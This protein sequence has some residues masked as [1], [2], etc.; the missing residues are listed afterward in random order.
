MVVNVYTIL[1]KA[2]TKQL[3]LIY[4][5]MTDKWA[6]RSGY[7]TSSPKDNDR[8]PE[9]QQEKSSKYSILNSFPVL[10]LRAGFAS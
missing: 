4:M 2:W 10:V 1:G 7:K 3:C 6:G 8:S 9:S 5:H